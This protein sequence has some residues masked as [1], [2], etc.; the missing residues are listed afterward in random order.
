MNMVVLSGMKRN[1]GI[2]GYRMK[3]YR[4][5]SNRRGQ[6]MVEYGLILAL[7]ALAFTVGALSVGE[8]IKNVHNSSSSTIANAIA[9]T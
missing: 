7:I 1:R 8:E 9:S 6:G 5:K 2:W 3:S 4:R